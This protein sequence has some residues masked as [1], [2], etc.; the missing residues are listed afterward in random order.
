MVRLGGSTQRRKGL[1]LVASVDCDRRSADTLIC[2]LVRFPSWHVQRAILCQHDEP[3]CTE[4][5]ATGRIL[6]QFKTI[7]LKL[8]RPSPG[9][10]ATSPLSFRATCRATLQ[11][12]GYT[13]RSCATC[14]PRRRSCALARNCASRTQTCTSKVDRPP[15]RITVPGLYASWY[16]TPPAATDFT[17]QLPVIELIGGAHCVPI[18]GQTG[19]GGTKFAPS[20]CSGGSWRLRSFGDQ[21]HI[22]SGAHVRFFRQIRATVHNVRN[23]AQP[24]RRAKKVVAGF[25]PPLPLASSRSAA[26]ISRRGAS[27][28]PL[29]PKFF[30]AGYAKRTRLVH[31]VT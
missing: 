25:R 23:I 29:R 28:E 19:V 30:L 12:N 2:S 13:P 27:D 18:T 4:V 16:E 6:E 9:K 11:A 7:C 5:L 17:R 26:T 20:S 1:P 22:R 24:S 10:C 3:G 15:A 14:A 8:S 21:R 31:S